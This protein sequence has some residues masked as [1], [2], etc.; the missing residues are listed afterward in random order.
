MNCACAHLNL[1]VLEG[2]GY[3][4]VDYVIGREPDPSLPRILLE[5]RSISRTH[6]KLSVLGNDRFVIEDLRSQN[7]TYVREKGGWRRVERADLGSADEVRL[8]M[9]VTTVSDLLARAI[10]T[11]ARVRMERNP[12]TGEIIKRRDDR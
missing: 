9:F 12:E 3:F 4:V 11:P 7:G 5:D 6:G 2:G 1:L 8:G 10:Y